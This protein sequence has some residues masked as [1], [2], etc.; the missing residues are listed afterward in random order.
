MCSKK[1]K[2]I[3]LHSHCI[4][5]SKKKLVYNFD[6]LPG[7]RISY[8]FICYIFYLRVSIGDSVANLS[9]LFLQL[10]MTWSPLSF[11]PSSRTPKYPLT[12]FIRPFQL[13]FAN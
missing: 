4:I 9:T 12:V 5:S 7:N 2:F 8:Q 3:Y 11:K 10:P 1:F 6:S 13:L